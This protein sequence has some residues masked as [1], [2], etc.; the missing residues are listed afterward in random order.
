[1]AS[2]IR[3]KQGVPLSPILF[4]LYIDELS[5]SLFN[6][7]IDELSHYVERFEDLEPCLAGIAMQ[8]LLNAHDI[9]LISD[10]PTGLQ[11]H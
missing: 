1:M 6:L 4:N 2:T 8:T 5:P 11:R 3:V 9:V 10:S 7:Y